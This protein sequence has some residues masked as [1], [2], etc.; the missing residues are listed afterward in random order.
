MLHIKFRG[1][2]STGTGKE[3]VF[4][5]Y[6]HDGHLGHVTSMMFISF[7]IIKFLVLEKKIF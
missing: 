7:K 2:R 4:T 6:G 3:E 1:N 5:I